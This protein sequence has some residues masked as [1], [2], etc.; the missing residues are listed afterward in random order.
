MPL[1]DEERIRRREVVDSEDQSPAGA[2]RASV[3]LDLPVDALR[4][5]VG[6]A[7]GAQPVDLVVGAVGSAV[8]SV[9]SCCW[10]FSGRVSGV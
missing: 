3:A 2:D 4:I 9:D 7:G 10:G 8:G 6:G 1:G 5:P